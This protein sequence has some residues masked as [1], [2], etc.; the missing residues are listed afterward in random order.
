M[1]ILNITKDSFSGDGCLNGEQAFLPGIL[2]KAKAMVRDGADIIDIGG[3][4]SRPGAERIKDSVELERVVPVVE[5]LSRSL[6][7]PL[8]VDT[9]KPR[10]LKAALRAGASI[11]N[12]IHATPVDPKLLHI[13]RDFK[14]GIILMHMRGTPRTMQKLVQYDD[15]IGEV[16]AELKKSVDKCLQ[17]GIKKEAVIVDPGVGFAKTS[18]QN[19]LLLRS[20]HRMR[21]L[22]APVMIGTSRKSF[23]GKVLS[24]DPQERIFGSMATIVSAVMNGAH[25]VRVHDVRAAV[26]TVRM[27]D[28]IMNVTSDGGT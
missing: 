19:L 22:H 13:V 24:L 3:E 12:I 7:V 4:S 15:L 26:Q 21:A 28:A 9:Y 17:S 25:I 1:G 10:V 14:A 8:S 2:R 6:A 16:T 11:A 5:C 18:G 27:V 23:I 20:L